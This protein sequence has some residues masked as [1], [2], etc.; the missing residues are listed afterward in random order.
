MK[1]KFIV[2]AIAAATMGFGSLSFAQSY[3][4][5]GDGQSGQQRHEQRT[6]QATRFE[7][8]GQGQRGWQ[9]A[10]DQRGYGGR[11]YEQQPVYYQ[12]PG[13]YRQPAYYDGG[14]AVSDR[15]GDV[16]LAALAGG[17]IAQLLVNH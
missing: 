2:C 4:S 15:A 14:Y 13:Y 12:Q 16:A 3:G 7:Q 1:S 10:R 11:G 17:L 9:Q 6:E 8:H 5:R